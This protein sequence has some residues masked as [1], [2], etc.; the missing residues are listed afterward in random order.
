[1]RDLTELHQLLDI[2]PQEL[3]II[4]Q[5]PHPTQFSHTMHIAAIDPSKPKPDYAKEGWPNEHGL[6][7][8]Q[9]TSTEL[10]KFLQEQNLSVGDCISLT[11]N[12]LIRVLR[13]DNIDPIDYFKFVANHEFIKKEKTT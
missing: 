9:M 10:L 4:I 8:E 5:E 13:Y 6:G 1:M 3:E 7:P 12:A 11:T 2:L